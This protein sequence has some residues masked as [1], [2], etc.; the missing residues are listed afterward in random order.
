M[1]IGFEEVVLITSNFNLHNY[2]NAKTQEH[3]NLKYEKI[4]SLEDQY[5]NHRIKEAGQD[6]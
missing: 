5:N 4:F 1:K 3:K 2:N 6:I